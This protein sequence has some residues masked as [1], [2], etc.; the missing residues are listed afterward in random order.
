MEGIERMGMGQ[1]EGMS[2]KKVQDKSGYFAPEVT[3]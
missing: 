2:M 3:D 1:D